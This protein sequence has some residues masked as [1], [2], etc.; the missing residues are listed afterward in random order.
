MK[1]TQTIVF[2]ASPMERN[3]PVK[4]GW[5]SQ[6]T[7]IEE[8]AFRH[9]VRGRTHK[10]LSNPLYAEDSK[11]FCNCNDKLSIGDKISFNGVEYSVTHVGGWVGDNR[12]VEIEFDYYSNS[13]IPD[14]KLHC[15]WL[16]A[17]IENRRLKREVKRLKAEA[18]KKANEEKRIK[19]I[20]IVFSSAID[21]LEL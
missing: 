10:V 20:E 17:F 2:S 12:D 5:V 19:E 1:K 8:I 6:S 7:G 14:Y 16:S 9:I 4:T 15:A 21:S 3:Y 13:D 18:A 11:I